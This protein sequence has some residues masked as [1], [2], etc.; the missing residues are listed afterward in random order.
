M[1]GSLDLRHFYFCKNQ[2]VFLFR[3]ADHSSIIN[4]V[5]SARKTDSGAKYQL[6][7]KNGAYV[8][9]VEC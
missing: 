5:K 6:S 8:C 9:F 1:A 2:I 7:L 3:M 4:N